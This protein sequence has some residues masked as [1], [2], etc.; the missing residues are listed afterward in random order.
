MDNNILLSIHPHHIAKIQTGEKRYE[1]RRS[2]PCRL[3]AGCR[4]LIYATY[5]VK[6]I[7]GSFQVGEIYDR[8]PAELWEPLQRYF[9]I[10][11]NKFSNYFEGCDVGTAI[12]IKNYQPLT[13]PIPRLDL[14]MMWGLVPPQSYRY[15]TND[16]FVDLL[17]YEKNM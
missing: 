13:N 16:L 17:N 7:V 9:G 4:G 1:L 2:N 11:K 10:D 3:S 8:H 5:P 6:R 14:I 12:E 15:I